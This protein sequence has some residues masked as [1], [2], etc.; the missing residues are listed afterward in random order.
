MEGHKG[1]DVAPS[2]K[3]VEL[4]REFLLERCECIC[5]VCHV[6]LIPA[7]SLWT[8]KIWTTFRNKGKIGERIFLCD[9]RVRIMHGETGAEDSREA[10]PQ[11]T[12]TNEALA[13]QSFLH[14]TMCDSACIMQAEWSAV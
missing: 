1:G 8:T 12:S 2:P 13:K 11:Q 14:E 6:F 4:S 3:G 10:R 7:V 9:F 5:H